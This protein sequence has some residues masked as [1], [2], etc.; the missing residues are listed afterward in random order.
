MFFPFRDSLLKLGYG[1]EEFVEKELGVEESPL[2]LEGWDKETLIAL[3]DSNTFPNSHNGVLLSGFFG[4]GRC[5]ATEPGS[6][7]VDLPWRRHLRNIR[8]REPHETCCG[9]SPSTELT[10]PP[11]EVIDANTLAY[12][13]FGVEDPEL[14]A[15]GNTYT[16]EVTIPDRLN[17]VGVPEPWPY[18]WVCPGFCSDDICVSSVYENDSMDE[19]DLPPFTGTRPRERLGPIPPIVL[20]DRTTFYDVEE[21]KNSDVDIDCPTSNM[22]GAFIE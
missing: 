16:A 2:A 1:V 8:N 10:W 20:G 21:V 5:G 14:F 19:P 3:F 6:P 11:Q 13:D 18:Y 22:P 17:A 15:L 7:M 4:C 9:V 12:D